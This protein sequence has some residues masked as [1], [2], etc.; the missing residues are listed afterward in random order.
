M[1]VILNTKLGEEAIKGLI[2]KYKEI[3]EE[4]GGTVSEVNEW[5]KRKLAYPIQYETDGYYV[6]YNFES[7]PDLPTELNR[8]S[9]IT[10][11]VLRSL[12]TV[13]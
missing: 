8:V 6:L 11:G 1:M 13:K 3:I 4:N 10:E 9:N 2:E 5:G 12:V 7:K